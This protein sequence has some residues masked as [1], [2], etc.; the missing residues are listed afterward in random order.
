MVLSCAYYDGTHKQAA[1]AAAVTDEGCAAI[2]EH[3]PV[4]KSSLYMG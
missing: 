3:V 1:A 4:V 2:A